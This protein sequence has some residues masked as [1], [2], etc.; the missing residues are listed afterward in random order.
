MNAKQI[1]QW[2]VCHA[3]EFVDECGEVNAT[4]LVETWDFDC[5]SGRDTLDPDHEAWTIAADVAAEY[6]TQTRYRQ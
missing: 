2:M 5:A 3:Q 6:E 4:K 1:R